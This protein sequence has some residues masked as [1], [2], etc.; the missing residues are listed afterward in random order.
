IGLVLG[1]GGLGR[2]RFGQPARIAVA[3][4]LTARQ[5]AEPRPD[6]A[7]ARRQIALV[8]GAELADPGDAVGG[9]PALHRAADA[10]QPADRLVG[11][12]TPRLGAADH[13]E[14]AR[15]VETGS[16]LGQELVVAEADRDG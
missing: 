3:A 10:P 8:E 6:P 13:R 4:V 1:E 14:T 11:E 5:A 12:K 7:V 9:E 2:D 16:Q 15:L